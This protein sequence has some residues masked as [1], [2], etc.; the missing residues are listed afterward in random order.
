MSISKIDVFDGPV[1]DRDRSRGAT[2]LAIFVTCLVMLLGGCVL[3]AYDRMR[4][5]DDVR[6]D[7]TS[8]PFWGPREINSYI[9]NVVPLFDSRGQS[10]AHRVALLAVGFVL[11]C[12]PLLR[13]LLSTFERPRIR[14]FVHWFAVC[15]SLIFYAFCLRYAGRPWWVPQLEVVV[16]LFALCMSLIFAAVLLRRAG[17]PWW[18]RLPE[19]RVLST[20]RPFAIGNR[21]GRNRLQRIGV[22]GVISLA[23]VVAANLPGVATNIDVTK[24]KIYDSIIFSEQHFSTVFGLADRLAAGD[25]LGDG[26]Y[27]KYGLLLHLALAAYQRHV[28]PLSMGDLIEFLQFSQFVYLACCV[29][30][31]YRFSRGRWWFCLLALLLVVPWYVY[32]HEAVLFPNQSAWRTIGFPLAILAIECVHGYGLFLSSPVLGC[33]AGL[34]LSLNTESGIASSLGLF[35]YLYFQALSS[36]SG[37]WVFRLF[38]LAL[39]P[40]G[41]I[42]SWLGLVLIIRSLLGYWLDPVILQQILHRL[43]FSSVT[44]I[45]G[46]RYR[47]EVL[48]A[49]L[50]A[51]SS[52]VL[53][54]TALARRQTV[55]LTDS[56]RICAAV[57]A[58]VWLSYFA[59]RPEYWNLSSFFFLYGFPAID[60]ARWLSCGVRRHR[61]W[62]P[63]WVLAFALTSVITMPY[64]L[65]N[66]R[67]NYNHRINSSR[68]RGGFGSSPGGPPAYSDHAPVSGIVVD[69]KLASEIES[70]ARAIARV[71]SAGPVIYVT[72]HSYLI[73]KVSGVNSALPI[74]GG[75]LFETWTRKDYERLLVFIR[76]S[77]AHAIYIDP[78]DPR[79]EGQMRYALDYYR[80]LLLDLQDGY[81]PD[82]TMDGWEVWTKR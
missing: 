29:L 58:L 55:G 72:M 11:F 68:L 28:R 64:M 53:I 31:Y 63:A 17:H 5:P 2:T 40:L 18:A 54:R 39:F 79:A 13:C 43:A 10:L 48:P 7:P 36:R 45:G 69:E 57:I 33:L 49:V 71:G 61:V 75:L 76:N 26:I 74:V 50:F 14:I 9:I 19:T 8:V 70:K 22:G 12:A 80:K 38:G 15:T 6:V 51:W 56:F 24:N 67:Y 30:V 25:R 41:L 16:C 27:P 3:K 21:P 20:S 1:I 44:G 73:P 52:W 82:H 47:G 65:N 34:L 23:I 81:R 59:N 4:K 35:A 60:A 32:N 66:A 77:G 78:P 62:D 46:M 37:R 42:A